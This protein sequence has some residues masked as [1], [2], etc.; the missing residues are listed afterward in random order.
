MSLIQCLRVFVVQSSAISNW[1]REFLHSLCC[2]WDSR[3]FVQ[4]RSNHEEGSDFVGSNFWTC[5]EASSSC[6]IQSNPSR[7]SPKVLTFLSLL[8][9]SPYTT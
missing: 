7:T 2:R 3:L 8:L 1:P 6:T 5:T 9:V 4:S